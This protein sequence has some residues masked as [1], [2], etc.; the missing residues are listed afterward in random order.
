MGP[1]YIPPR[2][3]WLLDALDRLIRI[4]RGLCTDSVVPSAPLARIKETKE[5]RVAL[6]ENHLV[7]IVKC[8]NGHEYPVESHYWHRTVGRES[9]ENGWASWTVAGRYPTSD[10][11]V[12]GH[13]LLNIE[14]FENWAEPPPTGRAKPDEHARK[15]WMTN[16][17]REVWRKTQEKPFQKVLVERCMTENGCSQREANAAFRDGVP[18]ELKRGAT[19]KR[20]QTSQQDS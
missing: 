5:L 10:R 11:Y 2:K 13:V 1:E 4:R 7:A 19:E 14:D 8:K 6:A 17:A 16:A 9:L 20:S 12:S 15:R 18:A 3:I